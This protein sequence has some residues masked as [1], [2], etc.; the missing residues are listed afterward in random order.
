MDPESKNQFASAR[1]LITGITIAA[2]VV[3]AIMFQT[4]YYDPP[5]PAAETTDA[6]PGLYCYEPYGSNVEP[7]HLAQFTFIKVNYL[8]DPLPDGS[9]GMSAWIYD[10]ASETSICE[11][12]APVPMQVLGDPAMDTLGHELLH[13][14]AGDFHAD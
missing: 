3:L 9:E 1:V 8:T 6:D 14:L 4:G 11:I 5:T 7:Q 10:P 12:W 2:M 13:C